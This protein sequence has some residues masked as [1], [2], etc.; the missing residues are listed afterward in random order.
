MSNVMVGSSSASANGF[1]DSLGSDFT[2]L[3]VI[4][5]SSVAESNFRSGGVSATVTVEV[6]APTASV[7]FTVTS[8]DTA[9]VT[10]SCTAF[11]NPCISAETV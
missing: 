7:R 4:T 8:P 2:R 9:T 1:R 3:S 11:E 10:F 5:V 6:I